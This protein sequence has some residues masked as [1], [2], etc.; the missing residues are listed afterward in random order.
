MLFDSYL[1]AQVL[2]AQ[3][4]FNTS[5]AGVIFVNMQELGSNEKI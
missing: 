1:R 3:E 4:I 5:N 2:L